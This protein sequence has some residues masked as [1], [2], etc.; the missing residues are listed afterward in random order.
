VKK[1]IKIVIIS[2]III[3][4]PVTVKALTL[5]IPKESSQIKIWFYLFI[6]TFFPAVE[7]RGAIPLAVLFYKEPVLLSFIVIT[8]ANIL[9]T[10]FVFLI[11]DLILLMARKVKPFGI[12]FNKYIV[13]LQ[14]RAK[15]LVYKYGFWGLL[16]FVAIPL[17]GTGAYSGALIAEIF[18]MNKW[19]AFFA[20]SL[21]VIGASIIV[22]L[23]VM[24][25]IPLKIK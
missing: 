1:L 10:P 24:G 17:P 7:L 3:I 4:V 14:K 9:I 15:P 21:G 22:T 20:V 8:I 2:T 11:W 16:I 18:G 13:G 19:K 5:Q 12:F 23:A 25:I 6:V